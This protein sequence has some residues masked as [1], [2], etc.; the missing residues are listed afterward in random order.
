M[1]NLL[2]SLNLIVGFLLLNACNNDFPKSDLHVH[3]TSNFSTNPIT[4]YEKAAALSN[5]MGIVFGIAEEIETN[6]LRINDS[7]LTNR[8]NIAKNLP[9]YIGLQ[10][11]QPGWRKL[12]SKNTLDNLDYFMED[13]LRFPD[14][15]GQIIFLWAT[16]E[17]FNDPEDFMNRY[18]NYNLKVLSDS[19]QIWANPTYLPESLAKMYDKLWTEKRMNILINAAIINNVAIEINS[20]FQIPSKKF[21]QLA[22]AAGAHFTFGSNQHDINIGDISWSIALATECKLKKKDFFI[23]KRVLMTK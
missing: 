20:N 12:Y 16:D 19:I 1:N 17:E 9:L 5:K 4:R 3:L 21:I 10:V 18:V 23:P 8:I 11:R 7:V 6:N 2:R 22:K 13:A 14:N 15:D